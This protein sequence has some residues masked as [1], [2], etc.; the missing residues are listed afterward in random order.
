MVKDIFQNC[1]VSGQLINVY[2]STV[3]FSEGIVNRQKQEIVDILPV[4]HQISLGNILAS[5]ILI[6]EEQ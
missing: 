2:K 1:N 6:I 3:Q 4:L 5:R